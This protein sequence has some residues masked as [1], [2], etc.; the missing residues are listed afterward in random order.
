MRIVFAAIPAYGHVYPMLPLATACA[1]AGHQVVIATGDPFVG[2]LKLPTISI[3]PAAMDLDQAVRETQRRHPGIDGLELTVAMFADTTAGIVK[4]NM[5]EVLAETGP[6]LVIFE[7]MNVGAGIAANVLGIPSVAFSIGMAQA[8]IG[9]INSAALD[10]HRETWASRHRPPP[11]DS[12]SFAGRL[13]DPTPPS[14]LKFSGGQD[15]SR[16]PIRPIAYGETGGALP[17]WL[18]APATR[19]RVYLTLGTVSF[20]AVEVLR[21]AVTEIAARDV[22]VLVAVGPDGDPAALGAV[23]AN[24]HIERFVAQAQVLELVDLVVHHGGYGTVLG[25]LAS[26]LPQLLLPQGADQFHNASSLADLGAARALTADQQSPGAIGAAVD[27]LL[28]QDAPERAVIAGL[29][30]EIAALPA[31][32]DVAAKLAELVAGD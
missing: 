10:Y 32:A 11:V 21:Q 27:A 29:R 28:Q 24:V 1:E 23:A 16:I 14:L 5:L 4:D 17:A 8:L 18:S 20:G 7:G 12:S 3:F 31:P 6:D 2:G 19:P 9:F 25:A 30:A 13:I 15:V 26:G 22:D